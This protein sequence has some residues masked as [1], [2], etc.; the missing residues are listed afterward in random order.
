MKTEKVIKTLAFATIAVI[1]SALL[2]MLVVM[3][4]DT[5][6]AL[7]CSIIFTIILL[8]VLYSTDS[9]KNEARNQIEKNLDASVREALDK[10]NIGILYYNDEYEITWVSEFFKQREMDHVG[11]KLLTFVPG[12]AE[13]LEDSSIVVDVEIMG[14]I[15]SV[16]KMD[17][18]SI[19]SFKDVTE[20][21]SLQ[22]KI[23]KNASVI[24][25][26]SYDNIDETN[27]SEDDIY[28][29][30]RNIKA[31][32]VEYFKAMGVAYST[33][34]NSRLLLILNEEIFEKIKKDRF[35]ILQTIRKEAKEDDLPITLSIAFSRGSDS[36]QD[37]YVKSESLIDLAQTRGGDQVVVSNQNGEIQYY[38]GISEAREKQSKTKVRVILNSLKDL[39]NKSDKVIIV[40]HKE[41]DADCIGSMICLSNVVSSF[42]KKAYIL[43]RTG[44]IEAMILDV[45]NKYG[46]ELNEKHNFIS[47]SEAKELLSDDTLVIMVDHHMSSQSGSSLIS[48]SA[49]K[50][51][52]IDHHRRQANLDTV[53]LLCYIEASASSSC[54]I[55][56]EFIPFLTK[57]QVLTAEEANMIYLGILIDTDHF[58]VR[59]G[60]RT[61][62]VCKVLKRLGANPTECEALCAEP[63]DN[64]I[65]RSQI[66]NNATKVLEG[67]V[68]SAMN[69]NT[70]S[71]SIASQ[72]CDQ[73]VKSKGIEA[74]FVI[75]LNSN[76][77]TIISARSKGN[78]NV[79][80]ILE[81]M[82]GGGH[83]T[84]AGLQ[85]DE[86]CV[87]KLET[88]LLQELDEYF[89][90]VK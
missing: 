2:M 28:N 39:I 70:Y 18:Y 45:L 13:L 27:L 87:A 54:E 85:V 32:V 47:E 56:S 90:E 76:R 61:F 12:V 16:T 52:I 20:I 36:Y 65:A 25:L 40:G 41:A 88:K 73:L 66:I 89:K 37:L 14:S 50:I 71:R 59:T 22:D 29:I 33:L 30:N 23:D 77:Q 72:A 79:Q 86:E 34:R 51:V 4:I 49:K 62:E 8:I 11:E 44:G 15:Y 3:K 38:G 82:G 83:M 17:K 81:K 1:L 46:N 6:V 19:L 43:S 75:C 5:T 10:G 24:G 53:P 31:P 42:D 9:I 35:S 7:V 60:S 58:R 80:I 55:T 74:A 57:K 67:V 64:V 21:R 78:I 26:L 69:E 68:V 84:A 63:Y 48:Q